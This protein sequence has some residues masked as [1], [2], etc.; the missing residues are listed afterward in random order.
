VPPKSGTRIGLADEFGA[1]AAVANGPDR[2][3]LTTREI[4]MNLVQFSRRENRSNQR[5]QLRRR[6]MVEGLEGR[7]LLTGGKHFDFS[8]DLDNVREAPNASQG[9]VADVQ[10]VRDAATRMPG[11]LPDVQRSR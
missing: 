4:P 6:P 1:R 3:P 10:E 8:A 7:Q 9:V 2:D 11:A 5:L